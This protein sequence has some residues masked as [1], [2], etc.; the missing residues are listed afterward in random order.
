MPLTTRE[1][2]AGAL[3]LSLAAGAAN[4]Q[5]AAEGSWTGSVQCRIDVTGAEYERHEDQTWTLTGEAPRIEGAMRIYPAVWKASGHGTA[6]MNTRRPRG[7][8]WT[9]EVPGQ[10]DQDVVLC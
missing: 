4:G 6:S 5:S 1:W 2:I 9:A 3:A 8:E 10:R 7:A